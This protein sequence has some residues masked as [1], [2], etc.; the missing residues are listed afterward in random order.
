MNMER[1]F[2]PK[3][4]E[5]TTERRNYILSS[6]IICSLHQILLGLSYREYNVDGTCR[7][8]MKINTY[9][10][11]GRKPRRKENLGDEAQMGR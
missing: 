9:K 10:I 11:V 1:T 5:V 8:H 4:D 7:M 2:E 3:R 6:F